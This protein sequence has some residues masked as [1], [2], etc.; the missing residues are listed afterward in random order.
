[1]RGRSTLEERAN[2][3]AEKMANFLREEAKDYKGRFSVARGHY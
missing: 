1:M 3:V 2:A